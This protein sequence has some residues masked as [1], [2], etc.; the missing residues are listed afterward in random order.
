MKIEKK[1]EC[2]QKIIAKKITYPT[3]NTQQLKEESII[4]LL[5]KMRE[6][7]D[8]AVHYSKIKGNI[9]YSP[10]EWMDEMI[11]ISHLIIDVSRKIWDSCFPEED[12]YPYYL[13]ELDYGMLAKCGNDRAVDVKL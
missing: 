2:L 6:R 8:V 11:D 12:H 13:R 9:M 10:Q 3:N 1:I 7:R 4:K 5:E